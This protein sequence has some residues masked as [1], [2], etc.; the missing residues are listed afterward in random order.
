MAIVGVAPPG[1]LLKK[2]RPE[3]APAP[4][5]KASVRTRVLRNSYISQV[6][7]FQFRLLHKMEGRWNGEATVYTPGA[8]PEVRVVAV[9]LKF[10]DAHGCWTERQ[11]LTTNTGLTNTQVFRYT[12]TAD[13]AV[14][15]TSDDP[16]LSDTTDI[17]LNEHSDNVLILTALLH[18]T[19]KPLIV[20]T[21]TV[22]DSLRRVR[23]VQ[24]FDATG[25]FQC[26]YLIREQRVIDSVSGAMAAYE[27]GTEE[28]ED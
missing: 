7:R 25:Q 16:Y 13:G 14:S 22:M 18:R 8:V 28:E 27:D 23:T 3:A 20:E 15:V 21:V 2:V 4:A 9:E 5:P 26:M 1:A 6:G 10:D 11:S 17:T 12:P 24:R 19:G